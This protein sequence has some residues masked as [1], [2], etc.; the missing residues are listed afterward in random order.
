MQAFLE[1]N[2]VAVIFD[3]TIS[4]FGTVILVAG[5]RKAGKFAGFT[6]KT[7]PLKRTAV[8]RWVEQW[9]SAY[10]DYLTAN[11]PERRSKLGPMG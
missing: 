11:A 2:S 8:R 5:G 6:V 9:S 7:L 10:F 4:R 3:V 1:V